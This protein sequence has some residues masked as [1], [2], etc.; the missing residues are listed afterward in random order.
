ME[1]I[2]EILGEEF[3]AYLEEVENSDDISLDFVESMLTEKINGLVCR[4]L[5]TL[6]KKKDA[7][8]LA[9]KVLRKTK[10]LVVERRNEGRTV[11]SVFGSVRYERTYYKKASGGYEYPIDAIAG[12]KAYDRLSEGCSAALVDSACHESYELSC[13]EVTNSQVSKQTVMNKIRKT[14]VPDTEP[15][16]EKKKVPIL[17]IDVDEDHVALQKRGKRTQVMTATVYEGVQK[18]CKG[19]NKCINAFSISGFGSTEAFW[20]KVYDEIDARYD[21]SNV[22]MYLHADGA[23]WIQAGLDWLPKN[24]QFV[25]DRYHVNKY[26]VKAVSGIPEPT[27]S[28]YRNTIWNTLKEGTKDFLNDLARSMEDSYPYRAETI[29]EGMGYLTNHFEGIQL[30]YTDK[31]ASCGSS[32]PHVQ[33][34]LSHRLSSTPMGW[35]PKTLEHLAPILAAGVFTF[36]PEE[37]KQKWDD[38]KPLNAT[39]AYRT[40]KVKKVTNSSGLVDPEKVVFLPTHN[41]KKTTLGDV[42]RILSR[43]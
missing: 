14:R 40:Q 22:K 30:N 43:N 39:K 24:T 2:I 37:K 36:E 12:V 21:L 42:L 13:K 23:E 27:K 15:L 16:A 9:D 26:V 32:E 28:I 6:Y 18:V 38:P 31:N 4:Y 25:V 41:Y 8:L 29:S 34:T 35:S 17:H 1:Q 7:V 10:G 33:H 5:G 19:R 20:E 3:K 11:L